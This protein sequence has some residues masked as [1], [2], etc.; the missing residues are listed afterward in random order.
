MSSKINQAL[1][2]MDGDP[3]DIIYRSTRDSEGRLDSTSPIVFG[4]KNLH[5]QLVASIHQKKEELRQRGWELAEWR[6]ISE[7]CKEYI[8]VEIVYFDGEV[9]RRYVEGD[10]P[11]TSP[12]PPA[13][14]EM[15]FKSEDKLQ[16]NVKRTSLMISSSHG[17]RPF[18]VAFIINLNG[19]HTTLMTKMFR[20]QE[21]KPKPTA[22]G[23]KTHRTAQSDKLVV[24]DTRRRSIWESIRQAYT[25][26]NT[27]EIRT[28]ICRSILS[29][30][31]DQA[32]FS[33]SR[34]ISSESERKPK[35]KDNVPSE[36]GVHYSQR[37]ELTSAH[38]A[39]PIERDYSLSSASSLL[40][41]RESSKNDRLS[42]LVDAAR[43][44][45]KQPRAM[46]LESA[47]AYETHMFDRREQREPSG[48]QF[49]GFSSTSSGSFPRSQTVPWTY[50]D[51][52]SGPDNFIQQ[53]FGG[54]HPPSV[55]HQPPPIPLGIGS[56]SQSQYLGFS[57]SY[58]DSY[59][60]PR[61]LSSSENTELPPQ[62]RKL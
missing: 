22:G 24:P 45:F 34:G 48:S 11:S 32:S 44:S 50:T 40:G 47:E 16:V 56:S 43:R 9:P 10:V 20:V 26:A 57:R 15:M 38:S 52:S 53:S 2:D 62:T 8:W 23:V 37:D 46:P 60:F 4:L 27:S 18:R 13:E 39:A 6:L 42:D 21:K 55:E 51:D 59:G 25:N 7:A 1:A 58:S 35:P 61:S 49:S 19:E 54:R 30:G 28:R 33:L 3:P 29:A 5:P 17:N 41:R 36:R 14:T 31:I 12:F